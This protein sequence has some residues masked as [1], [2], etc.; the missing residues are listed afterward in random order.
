MVAREKLKYECS[1][2]PSDRKGVNSS[3]RGPIEPTQISQH[4]CERG[5]SLLRTKDTE[6]DYKIGLSV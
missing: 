6:S 3:P 2:L 5:C 1:H 4:N